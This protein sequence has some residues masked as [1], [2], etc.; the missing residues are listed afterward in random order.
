MSVRRQLTQ[1]PTN[2]LRLI[3][4]QSLF[5]WRS[6]LHWTIDL[7]LQTI[8]QL[9]AALRLTIY[10]AFL[11]PNGQCRPGIFEDA[12]SFIST[13]GLDDSIQNAFPI[14]RIANGSRVENRYIV[15]LNDSVSTQ[16]METV[17]KVLGLIQGK[18]IYKYQTAFRGFAFSFPGQLPLE[19]LRKLPWIEYIEEDQH[20]DH[21]QVQQTDDLLWGLD[22]LDSKMDRQYAFDGTGKGVNVYILDSGID[23]THPEFGGRAKK[24]FSTQNVGADCSGHGTHVAGIIGSRNLGVAKEVNLFALQVIGCRETTNADLIAALDY[25]IKNHVKPAIINMS[26]GPR[27]DVASGRYPRSD[28]LDRTLSQVINAGI[29]VFAAAGNDANSGACEGSPAGTQGVI[30]VASIDQSGAR[31]P[32]SN[33]G[34]CVNVFAPGGSI[35]SLA[36]GGSFAI[37]SGTSQSAPYAAGVAALYLQKNPS[38]SPSQLADAI[39]QGAM[40]GIVS[41]AK[42]A[43][44]YVLQSLAIPSNLPGNQLVNLDSAATLRARILGAP[45]LTTW[46]L[47]LI[48]SFSVLV[49]AGAFIGGVFY[50]KKRQEK[51]AATQKRRTRRSPGSTKSPTSARSGRKTSSEEFEVVITEPPRSA[52]AK[53][54]SP[55]T[56]RPPSP[57]TPTEYQRSSSSVAPGEKRSRSPPSIMPPNVST[58]SPPKLLGPR[59]PPAHYNSVRQHRKKSPNSPADLLGPYGQQR[60]GP[61][62]VNVAPP[63]PLVNAK[64]QSPTSSE[65]GRIMSTF[66]DDT[67][68]YAG[69]NYF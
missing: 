26:L 31:S 63:S 13:L 55:T 54:V 39:R 36:P 3:A 41:D 37:K 53:S 40:Q 62:M 56:R 20:I 24:V 17:N 46:Q 52:R 5:V 45:V 68:N 48:I 50:Y 33:T 57:Q 1:Q 19:T 34:P 38:A 51:I 35:W 60:N 6:K 64:R 61:A 10:T 16:A 11:W 59:S 29:S 8:M 30:T 14:Y 69:T 22:R 4:S 44:N 47:T 7:L 23:E 58:R 32:F 15:K 21:Y 27:L 42:N 18:V 43:P 28:P 67:S 65:E 25:V 49:I 2:R 9:L 66:F 12:L